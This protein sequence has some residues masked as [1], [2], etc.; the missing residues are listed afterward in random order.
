[1][2]NLQTLS[3]AYLNHIAS[4]IAHLAAVALAIKIVEFVSRSKQDSSSAESSSSHASDKGDGCICFGRTEHHTRD[5][6]DGCRLTATKRREGDL[7][8]DYGEH[9]DPVG[10]F[11]NLR[12]DLWDCGS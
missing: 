6:S 8:C 7:S 9:H 4:F 12:C 11:C 1:M 5:F 3:L 10:R 2:Q